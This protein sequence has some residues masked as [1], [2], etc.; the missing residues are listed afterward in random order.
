ML[1][2]LFHRHP[3]WHRM[4][5]ILSNGISFPLTK[6]TPS[7]QIEDKAS[8]IA[9]GN[10]KGATINEKYFNELT[11]TDVVNGFALILPL[12]VLKHMNGVMFC[13]MNVI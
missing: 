6:L 2:K 7:I 8:A 5:T 13:P 3:L 11:H 1:K 10:H 12:D 9:F 4:N